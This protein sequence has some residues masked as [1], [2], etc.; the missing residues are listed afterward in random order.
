MFCINILSSFEP[1]VFSSDSQLIIFLHK[2]MQEVIG[3]TEVI[4]HGEPDRKTVSLNL[5]E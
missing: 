5:S 3:R 1:P 4:H 2:E